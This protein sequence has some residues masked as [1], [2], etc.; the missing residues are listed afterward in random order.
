ML[1]F[2]PELGSF[3]DYLTSSNSNQIQNLLDMHLGKCLYISKM[4]SMRKSGI[5]NNLEYW[6]KQIGVNSFVIM[7][8]KLPIDSSNSHSPGHSVNKKLRICLNPREPK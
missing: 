8:K 2:S 6:K 3:Q 7:E 5:W 4:L 1:M